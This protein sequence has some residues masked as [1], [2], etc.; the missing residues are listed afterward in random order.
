MN[1]HWSALGSLSS[2]VIGRFCIISTRYSKH[3]QSGIPSIQNGT[4]YTRYTKHTQSG[5]PSIQNGIGRL[6][7]DSRPKANVPLFVSEPTLFCRLWPSKYCDWERFY[8]LPRFIYAVCVSIYWLFHL[9]ICLENI[10]AN[11]IYGM[12]QL[13]RKLCD[14]P[15]LENRPTGRAESSSE[16]T[17]GQMLL[18]NLQNG[19]F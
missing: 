15:V 14:L 18:E 13:S 2:D 8:C 3:T 11:M 5:I 10:S 6:T 4:R 16:Q 7:A 1:Q 9:F 17:I 19:Q 12:C